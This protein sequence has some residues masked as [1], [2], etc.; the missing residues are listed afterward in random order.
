MFIF[1]CIWEVGYISQPWRRG[2]LQETSYESQQYTAL[3]SSELYPLGVPLYVL[4][5]SFCCGKLTAMGGL[6]GLVGPQSGCLPGPSC[7]EAAG[8]WLAGLGHKVAGCRTLGSPG[9]VLYHW[10]MESG[11]GDPEAGA[12]PPMDEARS[13][14]QCQPKGRQW[15]VLGS[16]CRAEG[17][18]RWQWTAG[19]WVWFLTQLTVGSMGP[20]ACVA[21]SA[22]GAWLSQSQR[23]FWPSGGW[24]ESAGCRDA[25]SCIWCPPTGGWSYSRDVIALGLV[26]L[27]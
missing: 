22:G 20:K 5:G 10:W 17:F 23:W 16:G 4:C 11:L 21:L 26:S 3:S 9:L 19:G 7:V 8:H 13:K 2:L 18:Q 24:A 6:V 25:F 12:S 27:R 14:G 15:Q 1:L